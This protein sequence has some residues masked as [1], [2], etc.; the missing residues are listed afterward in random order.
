MYLGNNID[1]HILWYLALF[2][3]RAFLA[4]VGGGVGLIPKLV[5]IIDYT[6]VK[7]LD[8]VAPV[9]PNRISSFPLAAI[10][11]VINV[12]AFDSVL[13]CGLEVVYGRY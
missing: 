13:D 7:I 2:H 10:L 9:L 11:V 6:N 4:S 3:P 1:H 5:L 8:D 12:S